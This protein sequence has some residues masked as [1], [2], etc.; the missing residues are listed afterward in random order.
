MS[1][2]IHNT[3]VGD[4]VRFAHPAHGTDAD[5]YMVA[6]NLDLIVMQDYEVSK[7]E[8]HS[9]YTRVWLKGMPESFN[10]VMFENVPKVEESNE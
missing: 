7:I 8:V 9:W 6:K 4:M 1:M 5:Q 10:S 2:N 3:K